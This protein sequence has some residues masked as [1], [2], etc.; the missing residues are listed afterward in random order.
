METAIIVITLGLVS[1]QL[2]CSLREAK[3]AFEYV[4]SDA[5]LSFYERLINEGIYLSE[6]LKS[7]RS[8]DFRLIINANNNVDEW[9]AKV[10]RLTRFTVVNSSHD[11]NLG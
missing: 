8:A 11:P 1:Y 10:H 9:D 5:D 7:L 6:Q 3:Q 2:Y 4:P